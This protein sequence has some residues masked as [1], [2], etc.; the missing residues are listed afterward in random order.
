MAAVIR[1]NTF[2]GG[3]DGVDI[4]AATSGGAS[5]NA[6][7]AP[8]VAGTQVFT[9]TSPIKGLVS[10]AF[11]AAAADAAYLEWDWPAGGGT[12]AYQR[13]Y[14]RAPTPMPTSTIYIIQSCSI[15]D[16]TGCQVRINSAGKI[17]LSDASDT[18]RATS[19]TV[20]TAGQVFRIESRHFASAT[21]GTVEARLFVAGNADGS[22]PDETI[23]PATGL[24]TSS[25][26]G[27]QRFGL[28]FSLPACT[29][30]GD[31]M[32][33][34]NSGWIGPTLGFSL[35]DPPGWTGGLTQVG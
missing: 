19:T 11:T 3:A 4:T 26:V 5:G 9:T 6:F 31:D 30:V 27:Q 22:T 10:A 23:G 32:A 15:S 29:I 20:L 7:D 28:A 13:A 14:F 17:E 8:G 12:L 21:V 34:S 25:G 1:A 24:D 16:T 18:V 2:E 33:V 35:D